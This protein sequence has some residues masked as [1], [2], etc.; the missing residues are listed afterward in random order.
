VRAPSLSTRPPPRFS[1]ASRRL[2]SCLAR[3]N[4][5]EQVPQ[6]GA[7]GHAE[8]AS[9]H[10]QAER[11]E[12]ALGRVVGIGHPLWPT[13]QRP[14]GERDESWEEPRPQLFGGTGVAGTELIEE[15][16]DRAAGIVEWRWCIHVVLT[17]SL[18]DPPLG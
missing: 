12:R 16:R 15:P 6:V 11:R 3:R 4:H 2:F 10:P 14:A 13:R 1:A 17:L 9:L 18:I 7:I 8:L 5:A